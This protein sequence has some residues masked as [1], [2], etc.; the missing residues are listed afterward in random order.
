MKTASCL[1]VEDEPNAAELILRYTERVPFLCCEKICYDAFSALNYLRS[2]PVEL[3]FLDIN[4]PGLSGLDLASTLAP[5]QKVIFTTAYSEYAFDSFSYFV[6]DY[7]LKPITFQRFMKAALKAQTILNLSAEEEKEAE[8]AT[9]FIKNGR[10]HEKI[11]FE[12]ILFIEGMR[13]YACLYTSSGT[14]L[15]YRRMKDLASS[16]PAEFLKVHNSYI[17][18]TLHIDS[19]TGNELVIGKK[20]IPISSGYR[21]KI[22]A[23]LKN[24][25]L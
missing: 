11:T 7:L 24:K 23:W 9:F 10:Q 4:L 20:R 18:N 1:I 13:E 15:V 17:V 12:E 19:V 6:I 8:P 22:T 14:T 5:S 3:I 21:N 16:L 25:M 2:T